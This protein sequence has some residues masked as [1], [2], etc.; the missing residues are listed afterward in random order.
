MRTKAAKVHLKKIVTMSWKTELVAENV[1][2]QLNSLQIT[3]I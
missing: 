1:K 3:R 2:C